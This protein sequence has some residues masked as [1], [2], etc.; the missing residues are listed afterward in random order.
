MS[1]VALG[2]RAAASSARVLTAL[3]IV[4]GV[5]MISGTFVL[6]DTISKAFDSDLHE[7]A[8]QHRRVVSGGKLV[9]CSASGRR[10]VSPQRA[11]PGAAA[12]GGRGGGRV[13][14][15]PATATRTG[16]ADRPRRQ[17]DS[18]T[19]T[20]RSG[21]ASTRASRASTRFGSPR[22]LGRRPGEVVIDA[23]HR[24]KHGFAVGDSIGVA[25]AG[26]GEPFTHH[27]HRTL[28]DVDSLGGATFALF[29]SRPRR[30][31]WRS[32]RLRRDLGRREPGVSPDAA[33][34]ASSGRRCRRRR[35]CRR[36]R[37]RRRRTRRRS[38]RSS[39]S[40]AASC[41]ASAGSRCSSARS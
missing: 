31:C 30:R 3:A 12:A 28:G 10:H 13:A 35:R 5:A 38:P 2:A 34:R 19:A 11:R 36:A 17:R 26:P 21:S 7:R 41:S 24:D 6:T 33:R 8:T 40:S 29:T 18:A 14:D 15:R 25:G 4:L 32:G 23:G 39:R 27:R 20:R 9:E 22:A 37:S 1:R 16:Q